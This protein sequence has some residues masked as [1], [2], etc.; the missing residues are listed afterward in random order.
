MKKSIKYHLVG[1]LTLILVKAHF[2]FGQVDQD[3]KLEYD[4]ILL[5]VSD[6]ALK[7]SLDRIFTPA[8]KLTTVHKSQGTI[9]YYYLFYNTY[10][11]LLFLQ[12]TTIAKANKENFG[13]DY[14]SR[15]IQDDSHCPIGFGMR[16]TLWDTSTV[17]TNFHKYQSSDSPD[18]E[19][20]LM[21]KNNNDLSKP[22][23]YVSQ[24]HR[25]YESLE[26]LKEIDE[27]PEEIRNDLKNYLTHRNNLKRISQIIY[28]HT[29]ESKVEGNMKILQDNTIIDTE[30]SNSTSLTLVFDNGRNG[31]KELM[32]NDQIQL[33]IKY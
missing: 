28:S 19:Y 8:E 11:E 2:G 17:T 12:D 6:H 3:H 16:M 24:P 26:S 13:S 21:S 5:F 15:W 32:L 14:L 30:K 22:F 9:G 23:V 1:L 31:K 33:I 10:I 20:Y 18:G 29:D 27:R 25:A 7:D 4:H